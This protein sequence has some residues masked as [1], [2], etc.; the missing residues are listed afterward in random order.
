MGKRQVF[1]TQT[2]TSEPSDLEIV[3]SRE[4]EAVIPSVPAAQ[5]I[6][7]VMGVPVGPPEKPKLAPLTDAEYD[8]YQQMSA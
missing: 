4:K 8:Y 5:N 3:F 6:R 7:T 2:Q 1:I